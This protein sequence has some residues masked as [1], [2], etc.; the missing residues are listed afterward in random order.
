MI[1][2]DFVGIRFQLPRGE[3]EEED[4]PDLAEL[5]PHLVKKSLTKSPPPK[6][7]PSKSKSKPKSVSTL[8]AEELEEYEMENGVQPKAKRKSG[9][10]PI[11]LAKKARKKVR[12]MEDLEEYEMENGVR[13]K[14]KKRKISEED[15]GSDTENQSGARKAAKKGEDGPKV[16]RAVSSLRL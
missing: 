7:G 6:A 13:P 4:L 3:E 5:H 16:S 10:D 9:P 14:A 8:T 11:E 1:L 15:E 2:T 12:D